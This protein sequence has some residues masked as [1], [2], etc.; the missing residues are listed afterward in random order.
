ME[1]TEDDYNEEIKCGRSGHKGT[2][3]HQSRS[4][5]GQRKMQ[6]GQMLS[7]EGVKIARAI[8]RTLDIAEQH[9]PV[10]IIMKDGKKV[11]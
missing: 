11:E 8:Q 7:V 5:V 6:R 1:L 3:A 4:T 2:R 9:G 10:R